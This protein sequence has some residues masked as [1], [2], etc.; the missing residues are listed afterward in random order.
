MGDYGAGLQE[1]ESDS[2][3]S[4][5]YKLSVA[6]RVLLDGKMLDFPASPATRVQLGGHELRGSLLA[7][8]VASES[9]RC[10]TNS[11]STGSWMKVFD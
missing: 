8:R 4:G 10:G 2:E 5:V 3:G 11:V 9:W 6:T 7:V 1:S